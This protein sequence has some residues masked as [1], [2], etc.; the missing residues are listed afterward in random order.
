MS[1]FRE[2]S[3]PT[4]QP[5]DHS[6]NNVAE[7]LVPHS[8]NLPGSLRE[9]PVN[10]YDNTSLPQAYERNLLEV[11][12]SPAT[13]PEAQPAQEKKNPGKGLVIGLTA[14]VATAAI[15]AASFMGIKAA[16]AEGNTEAPNSDPKANSEIDSP[17]ATPESY[18][19]NR[20]EIEIQ[21]GLSD[22]AFARAVLDRQSR[23]LN[24]GNED[25]LRTRKSEANLS[26]EELEQIIAKQNA[27]VYSAALFGDDW[28]S[29]PN[30]AYYAEKSQQTN[31]YTISRYSA[32]AWN[33][34][35]YPEN[36]EGYRY[37]REY[38]SVE[39]LPTEPGADRTIA[40]TYLNITN[41]D[42]NFW[43]TREA[44]MERSGVLTIS[45]KA[46]GD[47]EIITS[48]SGLAIE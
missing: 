1:E 8:G 23:W 38:A 31:Q 6:G 32:T 27:E 10:D 40:I 2:P 19:P 26:W 20:A 44:P 41:A 48:I 33:S 43:G 45:S 22:E 25:S 39:V 42:K 17:P 21:A 30:V 9:Q 14:G 3:F 5:T 12:T 11:P 36:L 15:A 18:L 47:T 24:E 35:Q 28:P 37:I 29:N 46:V 16:T 34:D 4:N 7:Q 13:I